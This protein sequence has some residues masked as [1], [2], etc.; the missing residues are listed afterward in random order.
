MKNIKT[1][2]LLL[3]IP[4]LSFGQLND[5]SGEILDGVSK[6]TKSYNTIKIDFIFKH[7]NEKST[8]NSIKGNV[9]VKKDKYLYTFGEQKVYCDGKTIWTFL[10]ETN[11]VTIS[12]AEE[13]SDDM[14][15]PAFFLDDYKKK[16]KTRLIRESV[17][18][19][20]SIQVIDLYPL[21]TESYHRVRLEIDKAKKQLLQFIIMEKDG[22][23][24]TYSIN[25]FITNQAINDSLFVFDENKFK[26]VEVID[27]R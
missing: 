13:G 2:L 17:E 24:Y 25:S 6:K 3:F 1:I 23:N 22:N 8:L 18:K 10:S 4:I 14:I 20:R 15:N 16:F 12:D 26:D 19:G 11:E 5:K 21:K 9:W 7:E 27:L